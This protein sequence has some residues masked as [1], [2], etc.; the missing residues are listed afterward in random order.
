[1][2]K[3]IPVC[4]L[5]PES[6]EASHV[7]N[8]NAFPEHVADLVILCMDSLSIFTFSIR[9][10]EPYIERDRRG[11][12]GA[13][14]TNK[15]FDGFTPDPKKP[16]VIVYHNALFLVALHLVLYSMK[17]FLDVYAQLVSRLIVP[18]ATVF[19]FNAANVDGRRIKGGRLINWLTESAPN[20]YTN[21]SALASAIKDNVS[22]WIEEAINWRD[23]LIHHGEIPN[24]HPMRV[25]PQCELHNVKTNAILLPQMPNG[26]NVITYCEETRKNLY[27]F[28]RETFILLPDIDFNLVNLDAINK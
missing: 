7:F 10:V 23:K 2:K 27:Q 18:N 24:L 5:G 9:Q 3:P 4:L 11:F 12:M 14:G 17:S 22:S 1:M 8:S 6:W 13:L 19:G 21:A 15:A 26:I 16:V 20:T 28:I 25:F